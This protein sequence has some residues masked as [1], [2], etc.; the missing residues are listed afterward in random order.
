MRRQPAQPMF[1]SRQN[2]KHWNARFSPSD[3]TLYFYAHVNMLVD[4]DMVV[5]DLGAGRAGWYEDHPDTHARR[6]RQLRGKVREVIAADRDPIVT[7]NR[8]VDRT[9]VIEAGKVPLSSGSVDLVICDYVLEHVEQP[10]EFV[11]EIHRLLRPGGWFCART[12]HRYHY[13]SLLARSLPEW[14]EQRILSKAQPGRQYIDVFR[15]HYRMNTLSELNAAFEQF[16]D[17]SFIYRSEPAYTFGSKIMYAAFDQV[18]RL[19]P[20][21]F[22]GNIFVF[23]QKRLKLTQSIAETAT[24]CDAE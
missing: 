24:C 9:V 1:L 3:G 18:H 14:L 22:S 20:A 17:A 7:T 6:F 21:C 4:R 11:S 2:M 5:L 19:M 8:S 15:K 13:V 16:E 12:P 10:S 23:K